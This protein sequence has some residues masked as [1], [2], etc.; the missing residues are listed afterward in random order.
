MAQHL[1]CFL[2]TYSISL[3]RC[4]ERRKTLRNRNSLPAL[5]KNRALKKFSLSITIIFRTT[6]RVRRN[7]LAFRASNSGTRG[8]ETESRFV[9][10]ESLVYVSAEY[11]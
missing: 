2:F 8:P 7:L 11:P 6:T 3:A 5:K 10:R 4:R 1:F 9:P